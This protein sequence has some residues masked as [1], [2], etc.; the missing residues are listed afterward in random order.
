M[1][2]FLATGFDWRAIIL[3]IVN[4]LV[5]FAIW[6]PFVIAANKMEEPEL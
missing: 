6:T 3:A 1:N 5:T 4:L 2:A